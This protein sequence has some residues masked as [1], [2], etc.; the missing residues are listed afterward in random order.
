MRSCRLSTLVLALATASCVQPARLVRSDAERVLATTTIDAPNP[1]EPG[2]YQVGTF[3]Y[4]SGT[5][6]RRAAFRDSVTV[7]TRAVNATPFLRGIDAKAAKKRWKYWGFNAR[8]LPVNGRVW[9]PVGEGS[10]PLVLIVHGNHDMK[11]YSDPGYEYLGR[12]FASRGY[13]AVSVDENFLNGG[14]RTEND[15]RGWMLLKHLEA[16]RT[17]AT[18]SASPV[19]GRVDMSRIALMGHSRG[20]EAVAVAAGFNQLS[21]YPDDARVRFDFGFDIR[22]IIAIAPV[23]GQYRPA[24][25][26]PPVNGVNYFVMHGSHDADVSVFSGQRTFLRTDVTD[27][28]VVKAALYVYRANHGQWNTVWGDNDVGPSGWLLNKR[29]LL[30]GDEQRRIGLLFFT[31]FLEM[32]LRNQRAYEPMFRDYRTVGSWLPPTMY[33]SSYRDARARV[34]ADYEE[35]VN[36]AT[37]SAPGV[38][39]AAQGLATWREGAMNGRSWGNPSFESHTAVLGW[40]AQTDSTADSLRAWYAVRLPESGAATLGLSARSALTFG[41]VDLGT[42][43]S[44]LSPADTA[45]P[46]LPGTPR[47][48]PAADTTAR[49]RRANRK[50]SPKPAKTDFPADSVRVDLTVALELADGRVAALPLSAVAT[51]RPP[52]T[53]RL[54]KY[55]WVEK[56]LTGTPRDHEY[57]LQ[58]VEVP[59]SRFATLIPDFDP[60]QVRGIR[61]RFDRT[62][63]G[64]ILLDDVGF[65]LR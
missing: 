23:D 41:I 6:K 5:D 61:F 45:A 26:L 49:R 51:L 34:I 8:A 62:P 37:G 7:R 60:A 52:L 21:H 2:A 25:R 38:R 40:T 20:G 59:F 11:E 9:Y 14:I 36:V 16:W 42:R 44:L 54:Y 39:I 29:S 50:T 57:V 19:R 30:T 3:T 35:D 31:G 47:A 55:K 46:P 17:I 24:D 18:D 58:H 64:T 56:Q 65:T 15:A 27:S 32:T 13:I 28:N 63:A 43:P 53:I 22:T 4:G 1:A 48:R 33:V 12:H 10:F